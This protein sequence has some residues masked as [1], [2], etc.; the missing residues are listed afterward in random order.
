MG[1]QTAGEGKLETVS[2]ISYEKENISLSAD[3]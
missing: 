2:Q 3:V 1:M